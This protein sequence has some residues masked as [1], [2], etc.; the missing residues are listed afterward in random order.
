MEEVR[1]IRDRGPDGTRGR[2]ASLGCAVTANTVL[3]LGKYFCTSP[4]FLLNLQTQSD[5]DF[6]EDRVVLG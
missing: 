1:V 4:Q 2:E 5:L 3:R 6:A